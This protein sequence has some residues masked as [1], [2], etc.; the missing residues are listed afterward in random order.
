[1]SWAWA[2]LQARKESVCVCVDNDKA[3]C[4]HGPGVMARTP[5]WSLLPN[6]PAPP[7]GFQSPAQ[8]G[9]EGGPRC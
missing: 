8:Q 4:Q 5:T 9:G 6:F 7:P 2:G 1:M 3:V